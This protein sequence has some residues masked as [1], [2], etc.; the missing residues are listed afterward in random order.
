M[1]IIDIGA[2]ADTLLQ[3]VFNRGVQLHRPVQRRVMTDSDG[4]TFSITASVGV[5]RIAERCSSTMALQAADGPL[6]SAKASGRNCLRHAQDIDRFGP[7]EGPVRKLP[8]T[9]VS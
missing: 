2:L 7:R 9:V 8:L 6:Y 1:R 4:G 5:A 3:K